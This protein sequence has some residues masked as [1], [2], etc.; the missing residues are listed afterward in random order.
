[1]TPSTASEYYLPDAYSQYNVSK[2]E[3]VE[4]I[5]SRLDSAIGFVD[6]IPVLENHS[7]EEIYLRTDHHWTPLGAYYAAQTFA[8]TAGV[9]FK[10]I[11]TYKKVDIENFSGT[12]AA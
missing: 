4:S 10:D 12:L 8:K 9:D 2:K 7:N 3:T 1:M 11:S 5:A 6:V